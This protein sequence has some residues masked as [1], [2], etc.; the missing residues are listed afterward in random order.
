MNT[1][2]VEPKR[3]DKRDNQARVGT[4][5]TTKEHE[6]Y[7]RI[8]FT[9]DHVLGTEVAEI[10]QIATSYISNLKSDRIMKVG[11]CPILSKSDNNLLPK[12]RKTV[13]G[14]EV[15]SLKD[16]MCLS[17]FKSEYGMSD[18]QIL[19]SIAT[20]IEIISGKKF[21]KFTDEFLDKIK[22]RNNIDNLIYA[23]DAK[24]FKELQQE[25]IIKYYYKLNDKKYLIIY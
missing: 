20:D 6:P 8:Y 2:I 9:E 25:D 1:N 23:C 22:Q 15:T 10:Q 3:T 12:I 19:N 24:E 18:E 4:K 14:T 16:K 13:L 17:Y 5:Y 7:H 21:I 11:N